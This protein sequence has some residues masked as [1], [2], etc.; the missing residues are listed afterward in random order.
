[1]RAI[2]PP[3]PNQLRGS[4]WLRDELSFV[5]NRHFADVS[6]ANEVDVRF[7]AC[8]KTRLGVISL[9]ADGRTSNIGINGLLSLPEVPYF[10]ARITIAHE[11]VHYAHGFGSPLPRKHRH[12]HRGRIVERE[13]RDRGLGAEYDVYQ[14]WI[15]DRWYDFYDRAALNS[16]IVVREPAGARGRETFESQ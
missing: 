8:W 5:W 9:S 16:A 3:Q 4:A 15:R 11:L 13:L 6:P 7:A 14:R 10:I 1:M 2:A 12:P